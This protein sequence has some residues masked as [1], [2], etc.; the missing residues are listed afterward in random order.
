MKKLNFYLNICLAA[1]C[2]VLLTN[3]SND[4]SKNND[5]IYLRGEMNNYLVL[6]EYKLTK[7]DDNT[8][9]TRAYLKQNLSPYKFKFGDESWK[10]GSSFGYLYPPGVYDLYGAMMALNPNSNYE[11]IT[12]PIEQS[13]WYNFCIIK[14]MDKYFLKITLQE[15][16]PNSQGAR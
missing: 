3:C 2:A 7:M 6:N 8:Y 14:K 15:Q 16:S 13:G 1:V 11:E 10:E 9:C 5:G 12:L 4:I